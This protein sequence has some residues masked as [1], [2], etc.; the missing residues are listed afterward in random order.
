MTRFAWGLVLV[1]GG[2]PAARAQDDMSRVAVAPVIGA[3][4]S[5]TNQLVNAV[6][7]VRGLEVV[8][9]REVRRAFGER[10][11]A[12]ALACA[13][14]PCPDH[15]AT[16]PLGWE[17]IIIGELRPEARTLRLTLIRPGP[18]GPSERV[19]VA[20]SY[21]EG[22]L[23]SALQAGVAELF[24][25]RVARS[26]SVVRVENLPA[27]AQLKLDDESPV[28]AQGALAERR[29]PP[30]AHR[31]E[32]RAP[33]REPWTEAFMVRLGEPLRLRAEL[34]KRRS[35]GPWLL[36]GGGLLAA[37]AGLALGV[38]AQQRADDWAEGCPSG[39]ACGPGFTRERYLADQ[40]AI[41]LENG[42]A[43]GLLAAGA[44]AVVGA[45]VWWLVD[46]GHSSPEDGF[47]VEPTANGL[48]V[49][50]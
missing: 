5:L 33:G 48:G 35:L 40:D 22:E 19:R 9:L 42:A 17:E 11:L 41:G 44:A 38:A 46:P 2:V 31:V 24:P 45:V 6:R 30:G 26:G 7:G 4:A 23:P 47:S 20:S 37:G 15:S 8:D 21:A 50:F 10:A 16:G 13:R 36:G 27:G 32:V 3:P 25:V 29:L 49:R 28:P 34:P 12:S 18:E 43:A 39:G 1:L 14:K